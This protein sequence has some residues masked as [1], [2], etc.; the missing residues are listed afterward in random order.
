MDLEISK[1][2]C[3]ITPSQVKI[4][5]FSGCFGQSYKSPQQPCLVV[6]GQMSG[7]FIN[8]QIDSLQWRI[9]GAPPHGPKFS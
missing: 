1:L 2:T 7:L 5:G 4:V 6:V 3:N 9:Q 8:K